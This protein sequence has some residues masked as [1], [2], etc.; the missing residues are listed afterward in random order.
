MQSRRDF[1]SCASWCGFSHKKDTMVG[2]AGHF[3][4]GPTPSQ[5]DRGK[6]GPYRIR[7]SPEGQG[8]RLRVVRLPVGQNAKAL[9]TPRT[10]SHDVQSHGIIP[11]LL[12]WFGPLG[13]LGLI[14][15]LILLCRLSTQPKTI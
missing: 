8:S 2:H 1:R 12:I 9:A 5:T 10:D 7:I 11:T 6:R 13:C 4:E 14:T 3:P 15:F